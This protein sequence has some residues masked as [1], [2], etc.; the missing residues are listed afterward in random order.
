MPEVQVR[1]RF[2]GLREHVW[3]VLVEIERYPEA[4]GALAGWLADGRLRNVEYVLDGIENASVAFCHMFEG[5]NFGKTL[6]RL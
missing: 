6:V 5:R 1:Q 3:E 4:M 2:E